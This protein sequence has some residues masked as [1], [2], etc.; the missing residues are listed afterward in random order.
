L[1]TDER[2]VLHD[3]PACLSANR[4]R[5]GSLDAEAAEADL[6]QRRLASGGSNQL[7]EMHWSGCKPMRSNTQDEE[8]CR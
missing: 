1:P 2:V 8:M 5:S 3:E 6:A 4:L 7:R